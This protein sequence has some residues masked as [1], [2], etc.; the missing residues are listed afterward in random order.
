M[1]GLSFLSRLSISQRIA[2]GFALVLLLLAASSGLALR[3]A[4]TVE[5]DAASAAHGAEAAQAAAQFGF[6]INEARR[7]LIN[8]V[9][10]ESGDVLVA[11]RGVDRSGRSRLFNTTEMHYV[12]RDCGVPQT[13]SELKIPR[14]A[15]PALAK[16]AL[17]VQRLLKNNL[18]TVTEADATKIYEAI[19]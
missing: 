12:Y 11:A 10:T 3:G 4:G 2:G 17:Q 1:T 16:S 18:R 5:H 15:I 13:L 6:V 8:Y 19:F 7:T 9:R 14:E